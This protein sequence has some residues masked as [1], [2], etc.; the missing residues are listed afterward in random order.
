MFVVRSPTVSESGCHRN[1][2]TTTP[3]STRRPSLLQLEQQVEVEREPEGPPSR[4]PTACQADLRTNMPGLRDEIGTPLQ[5]AWG[6]RPR[7]ADPQ[8]TSLRIDV[9]TGP[10][11]D[12]RRL[13]RI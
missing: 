11:G 8:F 5:N 13:I 9:P 2:D 6:P 10:E 7:L 12:D 3:T 1:D 4:P